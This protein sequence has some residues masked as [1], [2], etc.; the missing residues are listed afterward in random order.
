MISLALKWFQW[1][2]LPRLWEQ[3]ILLER[4][5]DCW[6]EQAIELSITAS[7]TP[8]D[9][10][11]SLK[12]VGRLRKI[13]WISQIWRTYPKHFHSRHFCYLYWSNNT[14]KNVEVFIINRGT[15]FQNLISSA[16]SVN[17]INATEKFLFYTQPKYCTEKCCIFFQATLL[18]HKVEL[19]KNDSEV[20]WIK[21]ALCVTHWCCWM[22]LIERKVYG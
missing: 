5:S 8:V 20:S 4:E 18:Y 16:F 2:L 21:F 22:L 14:K 1:T 19:I 6:V 15:K 11:A 7:Y 17:F 9:S 3:C 12:V 13:W 10:S